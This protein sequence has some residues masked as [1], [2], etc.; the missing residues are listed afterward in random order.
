MSREFDRL[1][2]SP[3]EQDA[4]ATC[5]EGSLE[6]ATKHL[7]EL[8]M[9]PPTDDPGTPSRVK[10]MSKEFDRLLQPRPVEKQLSLPVEV[11]RSLVRTSAD[12]SRDI[13]RQLRERRANLRRPSIGDEVNQILRPRSNTL[14]SPSSSRTAEAEPH[15]SI[16]ELLEQRRALM[17]RLLAQ[18]RGWR[19]EARTSF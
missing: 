9:A 4:I 1:R 19:V 3:A 2:V 5:L 17:E 6:S 10:R 16:E 8:A 15:R 12:S 7:E 18:R 14:P 11:E 13:V